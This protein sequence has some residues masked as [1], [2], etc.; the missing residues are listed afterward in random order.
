MQKLRNS[1]QRK[2]D[3]YV[4]ND[5]KYGA[6]EYYCDA[7][8]IQREF[9]HAR[10]RTFCTILWV[11]ASFK[12]YGVICVFVNIQASSLVKKAN[13]ILSTTRNECRRQQATT[14][15]YPSLKLRPFKLPVYSRSH[16]TCVDRCSRVTTPINT[17][18]CAR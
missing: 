2:L 4:V 3:L 8:D 11:F 14:V 16:V 13:E 12:R 15:S 6:F 5:L 9:A 18:A 1:S 7:Q 17:I 10:T